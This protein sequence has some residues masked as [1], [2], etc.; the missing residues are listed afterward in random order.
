M[1]HFKL[2]AYSMGGVRTS[3]RKELVTATSNLNLS[4]NHQA[5][6]KIKNFKSDSF[7][8]MTNSKETH[9]SVDVVFTLFLMYLYLFSSFF[10]IYPGDLYPFLRKP[11]VLIVDSY[12]SVAFQVKFS[13]IF[14]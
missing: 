2:D 5:E 1:F 10:S 11:L 13:L 3:N 6:S 7:N 9:W 8:K 14:F 4:A 12:N